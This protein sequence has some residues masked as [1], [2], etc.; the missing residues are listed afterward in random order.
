MAVA[1]R[2]LRREATSDPLL[3][4]GAV[5]AALGQFS[6]AT[7]VRLRIPAAELDLWT[8][9]V[10]LLPNPVM[11]PAVLVGEGMMLGDCTIET[12][13]GTADLGIRAQL[14]EVERVLLPSMARPPEQT[15]AGSSGQ[16][17][18]GA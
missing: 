11:R 8:Q 12:M 4:L 16:M 1:A 10:K 13:L 14:A 6:G 9:A 17:E 18:S 7:E 15:S 5:R 3:L 2:V